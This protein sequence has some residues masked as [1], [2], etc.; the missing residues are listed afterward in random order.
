M[1][2]NKWN[3][4]TYT[5]K[6]KTR[7]CTEAENEEKQ[8]CC[9]VNQKLHDAIVILCD[10]G[11]KDVAHAVRVEADSKTRVDMYGS[12]KKPIHPV[13]HRVRGEGMGWVAY[14]KLRGINH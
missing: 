9:A 12:E 11:A 1:N 8:A 14:C 2:K 3:F 4:F 6:G 10:F 5:A 7:P 13:G